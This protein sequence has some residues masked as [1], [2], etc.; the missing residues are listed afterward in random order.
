MPSHC[1]GDRSR[2]V[3]TVSK[4]RP[5]HYRSRNYRGC[6]HYHIHT[7]GPGTTGPVHKTQFQGQPHG[8]PRPLS[9][10]GYSHTLP[11][12]ARSMHAT[13]ARTC[14]RAV[15]PAQDCLVNDSSDGSGGA[16]PMK[17]YAPHNVENS[18]NP[19]ERARLH[20][21][22]RAPTCSP[23]PRTPSPPKRST[24]KKLHT[25]NSSWTTPTVARAAQGD[26][27]SKAAP[28][29]PQK[30]KRAAHAPHTNKRTGA[31]ATGGKRCPGCPAS[32]RDGVRT[33]DL[34]MAV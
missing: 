7:T 4:I 3:S 12:D 28:E 5:L 8:S 18:G 23:R 24:T 14:A 34:H 17:Q 26:A 32:L 27:A 31:Q 6:R 29:T 9:S 16:R 15:R 21:R 20:P 11:D 19:P 33:C 22:S 25:Y 30:G 10:L 1:G 13:S 2:V